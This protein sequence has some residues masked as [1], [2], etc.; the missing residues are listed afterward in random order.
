MSDQDDSVRGGSG[1]RWLYGLLLIVSVAVLGYRGYLAVQQQKREDAE[2]RHQK[3][4]GEHWATIKAA[5]GRG[6]NTSALWWLDKAY[7]SGHDDPRMRYLLPYLTTKLQQTVVTLPHDGEVT[8]ASFVGGGSQAL[9]ASTDGVARLWSLPDGKL[10]RKLAKVEGVLVGAW[11]SSG[12]ERLLTIDQEGVARLYDQT[13][14][15]PLA[16]LTDPG[17]GEGPLT[18]LTL[19]SNGQ[20]VLG[21]FVAEKQR[22][23]RLWNASTGQLLARL[24]GHEAAIYS[25]L[26]SPSGLRVATASPQTVKLW[27][28]KTGALIATLAGHTDQVRDIVFSPDSRRLVT[29]SSDRTARLW[30]AETGAL[31]AVLEGHDGTV[32]SASF[33]LASGRAVMTISADGTARLWDATTGASM[34]AP[35]SHP[36]R[37]QVLAMTKDGGRMVVLSENGVPELWERIRGHMRAQLIGHVGPVL[38]TAF[39]PTGRRIVTTGADGTVRLWDGRSGQSLLVL[40]GHHQRVASVTFSPDGQ[41]VLTGSRDGTARLFRSQINDLPL[42]LSGHL[43]EVVSLSFS[44]D[45]QRLL[46]GSRDGTAAVWDLKT[47]ERLAELP[48]RGV[49]EARW[50]TRPD[51]KLELVTIAPGGLGSTGRIPGVLRYFDGHSFAAGSSQGGD[52]AIGQVLALSPS[53]EQLL[54][55]VNGRALLWLR[56]EV[57]P[58]QPKTAEALPTKPPA[59]AASES[60]M[61]KPLGELR[62]QSEELLLAVFSPDGRWLATGS[63]RGEVMLYDVQDRFAPHRLPSHEGA[64]RTL[65]FSRRGDYLASGSSDSTA[66]LYDPAKH[67]VVATMTGHSGEVR[68]VMFGGDGARLLVLDS[69]ERAWLRDGRDGR[70]VA[71]LAKHSSREYAAIAMSPDGTRIAS[72]GDEL[73]IWDGQHGEL[74]AQLDDLGRA[75]VLSACSFGPDSALLATGSQQGQIQLRDVHLETRSSTVVHQDLLGISAYGDADERIRRSML[76]MIERK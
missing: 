1:R 8:V 16:Q 57:A 24:D 61:P 47:A 68:S 46:S 38:A 48:S 19:S 10:V 13:Q 11:Q 53:G 25:A 35:V 37:S 31:V 44:S 9:T 67:E 5:L 22:G 64:V 70:L 29:S 36:R 6:D 72:C 14:D 71:A 51:G 20:R 4:V 58:V 43:S 17:G 65:Q 3:A 2:R 42:P 27:D 40:R 73:R 74:L 32:H 49:A 15:T 7:Q 66:R 62:E 59:S 33:T 54:S 75:D 63:K 30:D 23:A 34:F 60:L 21:M 18:Q 69:G 39:S 26:L 56:H 41:Y 45:G 12:G 50:L 55:L 28:A 52:L 76:Q